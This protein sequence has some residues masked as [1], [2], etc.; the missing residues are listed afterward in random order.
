MSIADG[1]VRIFSVLKEGALLPKYQTAGSAG[2]DLHAYLT[3]PVTLNPMERK[4]I[5]T[6][7]FVE[8]PVGYELQVRPRSGLALKYGITVLNTPGTVDSDYR[9]ELCVLLVN[10][11]SEP[12]TIRNGDRIAQAVVA[13]AVQVS[14][15]QTD[16]LSK[17]GRGADGY[18]STGIA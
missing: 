7:L 5:P 1:A 2:A 13:Q 4:L 11:G 15:V 8:L 14:F 18:G 17:T 10:F 16:A 3:E 6:G 12:F 9:G